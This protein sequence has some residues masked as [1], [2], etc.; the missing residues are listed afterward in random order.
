[1]HQSSR[2]SLCGGTGVA[3]HHQLNDK[4]QVAQGKK[5]VSEEEMRQLLD[6]MQGNFNMVCD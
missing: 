3:N 4:D 2:S 6:A 5:V 1:M